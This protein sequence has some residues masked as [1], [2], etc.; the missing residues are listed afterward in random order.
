MCEY[1]E[2]WENISA[3]VR[4]FCRGTREARSWCCSWNCACGPW[5]LKWCW[6]VSGTVS[7]RKVVIQ[8]STIQGRLPS[9][10]RGTVNQSLDILTVSELN[11]LHCISTYRRVWI[12]HSKSVCSGNWRILLSH[13]KISIRALDGNKSFQ[14]EKIV[15][16][17]LQL[18]AIHGQRVT[19]WYIM[20]SW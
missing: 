15:W 17:A 3:G 5:K 9:S 16:T 4:W 11:S 19:I 10:F 20:K 6:H 1:I 13:W 8:M 14:L 2:E 7:L 12:D 18:L